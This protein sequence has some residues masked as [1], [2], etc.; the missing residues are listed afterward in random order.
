VDYGPSLPATPDSS[1]HTKEP[2]E[3]V[4]SYET[5]ASPVT[6]LP[7]LQNKGALPEYDRLEPLLEDDPA[8]YDLVAPVDMKVTEYSL[9]KRADLMFSKDHL[10]AIFEDPDLLAK[11]TSFLTEY[12]PDSLPLLIYYLD[13]VKAIR[14]INY[15]NAVAEALEPIGGYEFTEIPARPTV[16][17]ILED[18]AEK[19]FDELVKEDLPAY[20]AHTF[21]R[22]A[23][24]SV[25]QRVTGKLNDE[26]R[27]AS[28]GLAE[29]FCLTDPSRPDNP[30]VFASEGM[31]FYCSDILPS[32]PLIDGQ[33]S[34]ER[35]NT[36]Q[37]MYL[38]AT[39]AFY[40]VPRPT[41]IA[42][43]DWPWPAPTNAR[44]S[45]SS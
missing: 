2:T 14:A 12:R 34:T 43:N 1:V 9:E 26:L 39:V 17:S 8:S 36:V 19:A 40:K 25:Q 27:D 22:I 41:G 35:H 11:F 45:S 38:D 10:A 6:T 21:V 31:M 18:K 15:A 16:N 44:R 3:S 28:E 42:S 23:S 37:V 4:I 33:N 7:P 20:I 29:V 24:L 30:I 13:A 32:V 5:S